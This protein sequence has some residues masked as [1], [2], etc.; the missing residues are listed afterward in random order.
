MLFVQKIFAIQRGYKNQNSLSCCETL[1][2]LT[3][4]RAFIVWVE[5]KLD[6]VL[7]KY[8]LSMF[9]L[10]AQKVLANQDS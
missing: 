9:V 1:L 7:K 2:N 3:K 5:P 8:C 10:E 4:V 6:Q